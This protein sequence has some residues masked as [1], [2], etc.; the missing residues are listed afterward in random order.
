VI[1]FTPSINLNINMTKTYVAN[2][3]FLGFT[4]SRFSSVLPHKLW[5][6]VTSSTHSDSERAVT[7]VTS[8]FGELDIWIHQVLKQTVGNSTSND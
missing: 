6:T 1:H 4:S 2:V 8:S 7:H 3:G 5:S